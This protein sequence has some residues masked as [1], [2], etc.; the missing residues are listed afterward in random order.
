M[1]PLYALISGVEPGSDSGIWYWV[2]AGVFVIGLLA[3]IS[4]RI[5]KTKAALLGGMVMIVLPILDQ[6]EAFF[7][8]HYG[9]DYN[10]IFLLI[11]MMIMVNILAK[12]GVF[13][14][15]AVRLA[16]AGQ[17]RPLRI[18]ML[19]LLLT[20]VASAFLD[21][22]TTVLLIT[23]V[24]LLIADELDIDPIPFLLAEVLASN[25][26]GTATLIGDPP[27]IIIG[28]RAQLGFT[29]FLVHLAPVVIV[30]L[31]TFLIVT[32][33][34]CGKRMKVDEAKRMR[35]MRMD[36]SRLLKDPG[37]AIRSLSVLGLVLVG[38]MLHG[39]LHLQPATI[40]LTGA[41]VLLALTKGD[42]HKVLAD[43]EWSTIFFFIGLFIM[44]GGIVR[45]GVIGDLSGMVID[46]TNPT[47]EDMTA[48]ASLVLWA[49]GILS[50]FVDNIPYVATM[51]PLIQDTANAVFH[52]GTAD[53]AAL[54]LETLH[55][56]VLEPVW[57]ALALGSCLGGNGSP[58]G[59]S[60]NVIVIGIAGRAGVK[61]SF[62]RF[63]AVGIPT[64]LATLAISH[65]YLWLRYF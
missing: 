62:L 9:I 17:G 47:A 39:V 50:A 41:A 26:G 10:V 40:A 4:E 12:T 43:V 5:H 23:P 3:I 48:T 58:I 2:A 46:V 27:N 55:H 20:A 56:P 35:L 30:I 15:T 49:S 18:M 59:A 13:E 63:M 34:L 16:K 57:W 52:G 37:L 24:T 8:Q 7:S 22:V 31:I 65:V 61:I 1:P 19:F 64:M 33:L 11:G 6:E 29:D 53:S 38:F 36:E 60:A 14:W 51:S 44:V 42:P 21:N 25:I 45:V 54:P 32:H 28:S